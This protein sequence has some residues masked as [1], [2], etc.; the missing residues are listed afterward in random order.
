MSKADGGLLGRLRG[1]GRDD[2]S[3]PIWIA[4]IDADHRADFNRLKREL[5][6]AETAQ[7]D[8]RRNAPQT[9][10]TDLNGA[11]LRIIGRVSTGLRQLNAFLAEQIGD[12]AVT[13]QKRVPPALDLDHA[14][15]EIDSR[16]GQV[17]NERRADLVVLR[18]QELETLRDLNYFKRRHG[19]NRSAV[20]RSS[21]LLFFAI[22][23]GMFV[24]E[25]LANAFLLRRISEEGWVGG[26]A[27]AAVI[28]LINLGLGVIAG[29][30]GWRLVGHKFPMQRAVGWGVSIAALLLAFFW[31]LFA[32]HFREVAELAVDSNANI[33]NHAVDALA[34]IRAHGLFGLSTVFSWGLFALGMLVHFGASREAWDDMADRYW[35][36]KRYD[37]AYKI[38]RLDGDDAVAEAKE[39]SGIEAQEVLSDLEARFT[40]Q[41]QER[42][43]LN[44]A[45]EL[46]TRRL[47]EG[48][49]AEAEWLR[50]GDALLEAYRDENAHVR[51]DRPPSYFTRYPDP[52]VYRHGVAGEATAIPDADASRRAAERAQAQLQ[53]SAQAAAQVQGDNAAGLAALRSYVTESINGLQARIDGLKQVIDREADA[54]LARRTPELAEPARGA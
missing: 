2:T 7:D 38:A 53:A 4:E 13:A 21:A 9:A 14:R 49:D 20:Y 51:T 36:Y 26:V 17:L 41:T 23:V 1:G 37:Q 3:G 5:R 50:Q 19:L 46:A 8:G 39:T 30:V 12:A 34:H 11:Q 43:R 32:A 48:R 42:D 31:N 52:D 6:V 10:E 29:G 27:L 40:P 44:A 15:A 24:V 25:S 22:V 18:E 35:D 45:A 54:N 47:S 28:S 16:I 33:S